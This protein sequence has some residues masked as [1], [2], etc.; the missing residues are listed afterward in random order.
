M[1]LAIY[2]TETEC[3]AVYIGVS[4][5]PHEHSHLLTVGKLKPQPTNQPY[6]SSIVS[7]DTEVKLINFHSYLLSSI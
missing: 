6:L 4:H 1:A 3:A 2:C 5:P 7:K